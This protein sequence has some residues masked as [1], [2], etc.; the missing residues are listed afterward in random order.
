MSRLLFFNIIIIK[1]NQILVLHHPE[2][3]CSTTNQVACKVPLRLT[4]CFH[5]SKWEG[6]QFL[7]LSLSHGNPLPPT[8]CSPQS[9]GASI[10]YS[11]ILGVAMEWESTKIGIILSSTCRNSCV[12]VGST[13]HATHSLFKAIVFK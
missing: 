1:S 13:L 3:Y 2:T 11:Q 9:S 8:R 6:F 7:W 5:A 10:L 4:Q 12:H